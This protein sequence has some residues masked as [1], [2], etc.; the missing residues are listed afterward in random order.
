MNVGP[1]FTL[2]E[3][4]NG[5]FFFNNSVLPSKEEIGDT[6]LLEKTA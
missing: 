2:Q 6:R 1:S 4:K 3:P 5:T